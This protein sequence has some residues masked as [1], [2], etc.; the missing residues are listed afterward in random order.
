MEMKKDF[1]LLIK[2]AS[3][4][5]LVTVLGILASFIQVVTAGTV[6]AMV[7]VALV[8]AAFVAGVFLFGR[9]VRKN[10]RGIIFYSALVKS[11]LVDIEDRNQTN[12]P[13]PPNEFYP[14]AQNEIVI[15]GVTC[16]RTIDQHHEVLHKALSNGKRVYI[17]MFHPENPRLDEINEINQKDVKEELKSSI[18]LIKSKGL[19][20][21][22]R[23]HIRFVKNSPPYS[24]I[25][26][27]G[28]VA[29]ATDPP[30]DKD[31]QIRVQPYTMFF[32]TENGVILQFKNRVK[33]ADEEKTV[34]DYFAQD[35]RKQWHKATEDTELFK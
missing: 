24:C 4:F 6:W 25:M 8:I 1:F 31:G 30:N 26:I 11:G 16:F 22:E 32:T 13:L 27:D 34:F 35:L 21:S 29:S 23:L 12:L 3:L 28:D 7:A 10:P 9:L 19:Y 18:N 17:L 15:T 2:E 33:K 14:L 5:I 20:A